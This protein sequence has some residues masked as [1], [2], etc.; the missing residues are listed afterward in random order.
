MILK[1]MMCNSL[2]IKQVIAK[3]GLI[4]VIHSF[5]CWALQ[6]QS[7]LK[8]TLSTLCTLTANN[9]LALTLI[10]QSN[11]GAHPALASSSSNISGLTLLHSIIKTLQK[12]YLNSNK[13]L[14][15]AKFGFSLLTNCAQSSECKSIFWKS[16]LLQDFTAID[17]QSNKAN[18]SKSN[19]KKESL[20]LNFL[21]SLSFTSD[22]Q[23][24]ILKVENLLTTILNIFESYLTTDSD[25]SYLS[26][27]ILCGI[28]TLKEIP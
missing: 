5:W 16:N 22:G 12:S 19:F 10:A 14:I 7:L 18:S 3:S 25:I 2:E 6:D 21:V 17:F 11:I 15:I 8:T 1:H 26:M 13:S 9:K 20:W 24:L 23:Q 27:L 4:S 28:F